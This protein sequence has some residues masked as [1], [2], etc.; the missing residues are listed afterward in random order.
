MKY[1]TFFHKFFDS[2]QTRF[3]EVDDEAFWRYYSRCTIVQR[4]K[5]LECAMC[6]NIL[7]DT[8]HK[9]RQQFECLIMLWLV[10]AAPRVIAFEE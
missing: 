9:P 4:L 5:L 6:E 10:S 7:L 1:E 8:S 2:K 3:S